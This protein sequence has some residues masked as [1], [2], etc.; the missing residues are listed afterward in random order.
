MSDPLCGGLS[1]PIFNARRNNTFISFRRDHVSDGQGGWIIVYV[2]YLS[3]LGRIRPASSSEKETARQE[4]RAISHV[5]Y[6]THG[7]D[8]ARM[9]LVIGGGI[10][11]DIQGVREPSQAGHHLEI[12]C[13][14]T[15]RET[16]EIGT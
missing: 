4:Q 8:V 10:C 1:D 12:D 11:V 7:T 16:T 6:V 13:L 5:L 15:Q 3:F 14:E 9:D 2:Q